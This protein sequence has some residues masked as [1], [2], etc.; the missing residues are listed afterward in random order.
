MIDKDGDSVSRLPSTTKRNERKLS[1]RNLIIDLGQKT[2]YDGVKDFLLR[3]S[4]LCNIHFTFAPIYI[5]FLFHDFHDFIKKL[6][7]N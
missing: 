1:K 2:I 5:K 4:L 7:L 6:S 3:V